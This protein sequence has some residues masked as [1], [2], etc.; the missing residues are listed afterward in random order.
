M[1]AFVAHKDLKLFQRDFKNAFLNDFIEKE[2]YVKQPS[3]FEDHTLLDHVFKLQKT[4]YGLKQTPCAW[5][6]RLSPFLLENTFMRGKVDT[7]PKCV[8]SPFS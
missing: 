8:F 1:L 7:T 6:D 3:G 4:L 2:V 5:Y